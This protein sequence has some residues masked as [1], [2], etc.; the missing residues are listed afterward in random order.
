MNTKSNIG[1]VVWGN[2]DSYNYP[3]KIKIKNIDVTDEDV[4]I[5]GFS[6]DN[7]EYMFYQECCHSTCNEAKEQH[8]SDVKYICNNWD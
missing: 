1:D 8:N 3:I 5:I 2:T 7:N 6:Q 4:F